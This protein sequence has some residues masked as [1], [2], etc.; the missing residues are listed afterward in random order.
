MKA[1]TYIEKGHFALL[2]KPEP[3][4]LDPKD[5]I[6]CWYWKKLQPGSHRYEKSDIDAVED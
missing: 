1:Y 2:E 3:R 6:R 5:A 4:I